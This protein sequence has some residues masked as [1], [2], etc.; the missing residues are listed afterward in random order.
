MHD[1]YV[2]DKGIDCFTN[3]EDGPRMVPKKGSGGHLKI[4][5]FNISSEISCSILTKLS[6]NATLELGLSELLKLGAGIHQGGKKWQ[7]FSSQI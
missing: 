7:I 5:I 4:H 1:P 2:Y 3:C 6:M